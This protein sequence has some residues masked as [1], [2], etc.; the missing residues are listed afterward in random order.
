MAGTAMADNFN[1]GNTYAQAWQGFGTSPY[2]AVN[3]VTNQPIVI[4]CLDY[5]DEIAPPYNWNANVWT[6]NAQ[7]VQTEAQY[8]GNY[9]N[10]LNTA[11]GATHPGQTA[12]NPISGP[13]YA[14][15]TDSAGA[16]SVDLSAS[17]DPY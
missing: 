7:N 4:F 2:V 17:S 10:L 3:T 14:F 9:N 15:V 8:G 6:L 13:P 11:Y 1:W 12:P 16:Y 5:N